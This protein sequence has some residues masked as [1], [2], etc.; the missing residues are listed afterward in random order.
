M[1]LYER[2]SV[3]ES[4]V[5]TKFGS[6]KQ[7]GAS[8]VIRRSD[9]KRYRFAVFECICGN[10]SLTSMSNARNSK[11]GLCRQCSNKKHGKSNSLEHTAWK[12]M[13]ARCTNPNVERYGNYG[14]RGIT[15]CERWG[16]SFEA[17]LEDMGHVPPGHQIDRID[18]DGNYEPGNCRWVTR[19]QNG[20]NK[21]NNRLVEYE[22]NTM[23]IPEISEKTGVKAGTIRCR[24]ARGLSVAQ[25]VRI[26]LACVLMSFS[27]AFAV[28]PQDWPYCAIAK[29]TA[30]NR[31]G[32]ASLIGMSGTRGL[33]VTAA[34][35][36]GR[37]KTVSLEFPNG[38]KCSGRVLDSD[39]SIDIA[40]LECEVLPTMRTLRRVRAVRVGDGTLT[41]VGFPAY[42]RDKPCYTQGRFTGY[43]GSKAMIATPR[44]I[45][46]GY[47]GGALLS[48]TAELIGITN[49]AARRE[50]LAASGESMESFIG[51][52]MPT[53]DK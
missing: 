1:G 20:R 15:V 34:H 52:F 41:A 10:I 22:G 39:A 30:G 43:S 17:F 37:A 51:R 8:F 42:S 31:G 6:R 33:V 2:L 5:G 50:T 53:G 26:A 3:D 28:T 29:I 11:T 19:K 49:W 46:S 24:I 45:S 7:T 25:A 38:H 16:N 47:S 40:A 21:R 27:S 18:N 32:S 23:T 12:S 14:G 4:G 9:G 44:P 48:E 36:V 35:V 13:K